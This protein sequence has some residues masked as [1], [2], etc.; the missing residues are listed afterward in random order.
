LLYSSPQTIFGIPT[1][2]QCVVSAISF[3]WVRGALQAVREADRA[4]ELDYLYRELAHV[5]EIDAVTGLPNHRVIMEHMLQEVMQC[6]YTDQS[7]AILFVDLDH[8]K[9]IND[10]WGHLVGDAVLRE[11]ARRLHATV[12]PDGIVGRYGGEEFAVVLKGVDLYRAHKIAEQ[13]RMA[14][15][16]SEYAL[17]ID[18]KKVALIVTA[19]IG[20]AMYGMH[21]TIPTTLLEQADHAMYRAKEHGRNCVWVVGAQ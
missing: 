1:L 2:L 8:F 11:V 21:G 9:Q 3:L 5:A 14:I 4:D 12:T 18:D 10:T 19:S 15:A 16:S 20:V 7:C 6:K 13:A 17:Q